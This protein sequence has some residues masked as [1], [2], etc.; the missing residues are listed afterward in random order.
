MDASSCWCKIKRLNRGR[1]MFKIN[2]IFR[3]HQA[4]KPL[5]LEADSRERLQQLWQLTAP[6]YQHLSQVLALEHGQLILHVA[7][8][9]VAS[10]I[11]LLEATLVTKLHDFNRKTSKIKGLNL[12]AIKVKVQV[13]SQPKAKQK[14]IQA[15]SSHALSAL[16]NCA[17]TIENDALK[18]ALQRFIRHQR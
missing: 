4:L 2:H 13:K 1:S 12:N 9:A 10:R 6:E 7:S 16:A 3:N 14:R 18:Q 15:P 5:L 17:D 11:K 8:G